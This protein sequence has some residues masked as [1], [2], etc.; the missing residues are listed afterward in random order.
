MGVV[1]S[2]YGKEARRSRIR[3]YI[4]AY[5]AK[6]RYLQEVSCC[7]KEFSHGQI[8][9]PEAVEIETVNR[10]NNDCPFCPVNRNEKQREYHQMSDSLFYKI[11]M[12][13]S[14][15]GYTGILQLFSNNEPLLDKKIYERLK[16][17]KEKVPSA[18]M[19]LLSNGILLK[20][21]RVP[22]LLDSLDMLVI[23]NYDDRL[24]M[25]PAVKKLYHW[26]KRNPEYEKKVEIHMR[27]KNEILTTRG[28]DSPNS[29][30]V[31]NGKAKWGCIYPFKQMVIRPDGKVSLCCNDALGKVTLGDVGK[32][33]LMEIWHSRRYQTIRKV[34]GSGRGNFEKCAM[35]DTAYHMWKPEV[36]L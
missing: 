32:Q 15:I 10:C 8:P 23:D 22:E 24:Q 31:K 35:C 14:E 30:P 34:V 27:K 29:R 5:R 19:L 16:L 25:L 2:R 21:D 3:T 1:Y 36:S 12:E 9:L 33:S 4:G 18:Y 13:L 26:V 11:L 20:E 7:R 6:Q 28:G 17:A